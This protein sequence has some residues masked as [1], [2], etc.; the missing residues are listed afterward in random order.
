MTP[1]DFNQLRI[2]EE[3]RLRSI[4][5]KYDT[6]QYLR[7]LAA[8]YEGLDPSHEVV[9]CRALA[10]EAKYRRQE[11]DRIERRTPDEAAA[12]AAYPILRSDSYVFGLPAR[13]AHAIA[14]HAARGKYFVV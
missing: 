5:G 13:Y 8:W 9:G 14:G 10:E 2:A 6:P 12:E 1:Y 11:A 7:A 3:R 4:H